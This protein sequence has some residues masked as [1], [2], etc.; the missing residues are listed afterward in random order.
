[1]GTY[2]GWANV[3]KIV[4]RKRWRRGVSKKMFRNIKRIARA[5]D[6]VHWANIYDA[7]S[8]V[9][10]VPSPMT[11]AQGIA[12]CNDDATRAN[13]KILKPFEDAIDYENG[14]RG[15]EFGDKSLHKI[16]SRQ[17][18]LKGI[19]YRL[20]F[21]PTAGTAA[22]VHWPVR[23]VWGYWT[24]TYDGSSYDN[25]DLEGLFTIHQNFNSDA[26]T[27]GIGT[28][29]EVIYPCPVNREDPKLALRK[30]FKILGN[31]LFFVGEGE[32]DTAGNA[33]IWSQ[34][35][36]QK[37]MTIKFPPMKI[38]FGQYGATDATDLQ[39]PIG[40]HKTPF[41][42]AFTKTGGTVDMQWEGRMYWKNLN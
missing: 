8:G 27:S 33:N 42:A 7:T 3:T 13:S 19:T 23:V 25:V 26:S 15:L 14:T 18:F 21:Y 37:Y 32:A 6:E 20:H 40:R 16:S 39:Y 38:R 30:H 35:K 36:K 28:I 1:M 5:D 11:L 12:A 31:R 17:I 29:D 24:S 4:P 41:I 22:G 34:G 9:T 10:T 2:G